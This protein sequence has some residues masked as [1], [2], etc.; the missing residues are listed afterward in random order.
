MLKDQ[1]T[2]VTTASSLLSPMQC[3][4]FVFKNQNFPELNLPTGSH[5]GF[6][7][8]DVEAVLPNLV[9]EFFHP[10]TYDTLGTIITPATNVKAVN[11]QEFIPLLV[12]AFNEQKQVIDSLLNALSVATPGA[13][14]RSLNT[15]SSSQKVTLS[16]SHGIILNQN[17]PNPFME[18]TTI[19]Y[20]IPVEI[21]DAKLLFSDNK[22][23]I[24]KTV[25]IESRGIGSLDV[26]ASELSTGIYTYSLVCDGKVIESKKMMK[27]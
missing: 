23:M 20:T 24:F 7:A 8:Q 2:P 1:I 16:D 17:D 27:N 13:G 9:K 4:Q 22:G 25:E 21:K 6:I 14:N 26:Y 3:K 19:R 10:A 15:N 5:Y 18:S 11:Y 12:A